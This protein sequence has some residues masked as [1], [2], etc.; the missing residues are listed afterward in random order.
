MPLL[1][2]DLCLVQCHIFAI[3][4]YKLSF[5][6]LLKAAKKNQIIIYANLESTR[7]IIIHTMYSAK[8]DNNVSSA[9]QRLLTAADPT[10]LVPEHDYVVFIHQ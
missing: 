5:S 2:N 9:H 4:L 6:Q 7:F 10:G 1:A 3:G 8:K